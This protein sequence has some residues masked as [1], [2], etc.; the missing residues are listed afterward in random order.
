MLLFSHKAELEKKYRNWLEEKSKQGAVLQ[1]CPVN[2][3]NFLYG[4]GFLN[5][6]KILERIGNTEHNTH[7]VVSNE[8]CTK[9]DTRCSCLLRLNS[10]AESLY[11]WTD[12][13]N[14]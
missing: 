8:K 6:E 5:E 11:Q 10:E 7:D 3:I 14:I 4:Q 2:V 12:Y 1:D 9:C 13:W